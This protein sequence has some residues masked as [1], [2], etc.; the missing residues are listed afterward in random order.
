MDIDIADPR[1][2]QYAAEHTS[3]EPAYFAVLADR[4]RAET[5]A[6]GMM[7]GTL[8]GRFLS[9]LVALARP[10]LVLELG[11]F[12]GY[13]ALSMAESLPP[14]GRIITCDISEEHV[15]M[16]R[17]NFAASPFADRIEIKVGPALES[18]AALDGPFDLMFIDADK[19]SYLA[20]YEA[21]L[22]KLAADG[23]MLVDNVLWS[24]RILDSEDDSESTTALREFNDRVAADERVEVVMLT[25]RDGV[26]LIRHRRAAPTD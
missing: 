2:E 17:R 24:G 8:E 20:Y 18:I 16:A 9:A 21:L 10:Q 23:A 13:S 11:T 6:P 12:T 19:V 22:P 25:V 5:S 14:G 3:G 4:T 26:S 15:T 7:V 1:V